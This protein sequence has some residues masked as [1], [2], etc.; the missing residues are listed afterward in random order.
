MTTETYRAAVKTISDQHDPIIDGLAAKAEAMIEKH[1]S[2]GSYIPNWPDAAT[3]AEY[4]ALDAQWKAA[5]AAR[6]QEAKIAAELL[7]A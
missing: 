7:S 1:C 4:V 5:I 6:N 3:H 2:D